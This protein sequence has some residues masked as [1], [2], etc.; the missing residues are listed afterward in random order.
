MQDPFTRV[1]KA[2]MGKGP[3]KYKIS[4]VLILLPANWTLQ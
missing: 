4:S 3:I 1:I 2:T